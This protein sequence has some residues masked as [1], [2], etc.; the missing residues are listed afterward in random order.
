MD[1]QTNEQYL[2]SVLT[3]LLGKFPCLAVPGDLPH[4]I[5]IASP[6]QHLREEDD[7]PMTQ[8]DPITPLHE[9]RREF[10]ALG[11]LLAYVV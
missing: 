11:E 6:E 8:K 9:K 4:E 5:D 1:R 7:I 10:K 2:S 3:P